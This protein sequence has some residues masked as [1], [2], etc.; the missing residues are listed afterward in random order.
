MGRYDLNEKEWELE[1]QREADA[2][3]TFLRE[4]QAIPT[5][6]EIYAIWIELYSRQGGKII[7]RDRN[8]E[9]TA[10]VDERNNTY[11]VDGEENTAIAYENLGWRD[12][13]PT[14]NGGQIPANYGSS[15]M[16]LLV[17]PEVT[18][19]SLTSAT[20][21]WREG[22]EWG[23]TTVLSVVRDNQFSS[24]FRAET[25]KQ[26]GVDSYKDVEEL[27]KSM[28]LE[29]MLAKYNL[30]KGTKGISTQKQSLVVSSPGLSLAKGKEAPE[31]KGF[32]KML[33]WFRAA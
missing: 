3:L 12:W 22:W 27:R 26:Y 1:H 21:D 18:G 28:N 19:Q 5:P 25:N 30:R 23:H 10:H 9:K 15:S 20:E 7:V 8:Y 33:S 17:L 14:R 6:I 11:Y 31:K 32:G 29:Q 4:S 13:C 16:T 2:R 24:G